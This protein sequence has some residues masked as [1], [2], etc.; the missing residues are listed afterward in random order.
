MKYKKS[1]E[2][3][4]LE[5]LI[6]QRE[7]KKDPKAKK[8]YYYDKSEK[9]LI[10]C[11]GNYTFLLGGH[12]EKVTSMGRS[13]N[14]EGKQIFVPNNNTSGQSDMSLIINGKAIKVE[15]KCKWTGDKYQSKEQKKYQ[16]SVERAKGRYLIVREFKDFKNWLDKY[17]S[18]E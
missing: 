4:E 7:L 11:I 5:N 1:K 8:K 13:L 14:K 18:Y 16:K 10:K 3:K 17:L 6:H 15:V 9:D 12:A 2:V